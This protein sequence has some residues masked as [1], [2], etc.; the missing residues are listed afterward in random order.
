MII[1]YWKDSAQVV[2][3]TFMMVIPNLLELKH[4]EGKLYIE[5]KSDPLIND[6]SNVGW[7][8]VPEQEIKPP[9]IEEILD[10]N[11]IILPRTIG[12]L[13][14][15]LFTVDT[16]TMSQHYAILTAI[17]PS[18]PLFKALVKRWFNDQWFEDIPCAVGSW[19]VYAFQNNLI[20]IGD[21]VV[22]GYIPNPINNG[23]IPFLFDKVE[24]E[25]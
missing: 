3:C 6:T 9:I 1:L 2:N 14:L 10:G 22:I 24:E 16:L 13:S 12:E 20:S 8:A 19:A 23:F 17:T 11:E 7:F 25:L 18:N 5:G 4:V 21:K 15:I